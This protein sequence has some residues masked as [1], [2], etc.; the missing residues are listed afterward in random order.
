MKST[1]ILILLIFIYG[2]GKKGSLEY[3][4]VETGYLYQS[5]TVKV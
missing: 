3:P 2:C 5:S 1:S 4:P